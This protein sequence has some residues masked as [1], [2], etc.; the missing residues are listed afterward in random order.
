MHSFRFPVLGS[1]VC[2]LLLFPASLPQLFHRCSLLFR[3]PFGSL[4]FRVFRFPSAFFRSLPF[5][6]QLLGFLFFPF[7]FLPVFASQWL[8]SVLPFRFRFQ[9]LSSSVPPGFPCFSSDSQYLAFLMVSFRSTLLRSR[10][11]STGD[12]LLLSLS[13]PFPCFH[14]LSSVS[15]LGFQL[16][17]L[18]FFFSRF[19]RFRLTV[20]SPV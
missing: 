16:L 5:H 19:P 13:V 3:S 7:L 18:C 15:A 11:R 4:L 6:F 9:D 17:S 1:T 2:F 20:A 10:S 8:F 14:F 12:H